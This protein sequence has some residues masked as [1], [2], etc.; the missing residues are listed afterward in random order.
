ME[1]CIPLVKDASLYK[2]I[3]KNIVNP[4]EVP[5]EAISNSI[6]AEAKNINIEL[7]RNN[8]GLFCIDFIDDGIGMGR[9]E[10]ERFFNLGD[11]CKD[12]R[13]IGEK[14]LG[15]KIFFRSKR[16]TVISQKENSERT[17]AVMDDPW[18]NLSNGKVPVYTIDNDAPIV[19]NDG[20]SVKIEGYLIDNPEKYFNFYTLKDYILWFT[21]GG[22]FKN[23]FATYSELN[24]YVKN[25]QVAPRIFINDKIQQVREEIGGTH[26]FYPPQENPKEDEHEKVYRKSVNYCRHFGPYHRSTNI[27]GEYVS[28]QMYGTVSGVNCRKS[29]CKLRHSERLK[30]RFGVYL[31][32]DFIPVTKKSSLITNP[33]YHHFH[34]VVNSQNF[35]LTADRN[36]I[37]NQDDPKVKWILS[38]AKKIIDEDI[39][40]I[41]ESVYFKM[42][43][44]EECQAQIQDKNLALKNR[45]INFSKL[46]GLNI[47]DIPIKKVPDNESQVALLLTSLLSNNKFKQHIKY[48]DSIAHYSQHS[49][50]DLICINNEGNPLLVEMEFLLSNIFKHDH[51]YETFDCIVC[52]K[53]DIEVNEKKKLI[54][55]TE[56]KLICERERWLL[57]FGADKIIPIIELSDVIREVSDS[58][59]FENIL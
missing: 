19:G 42:R 49:T 4:L 14:G 39:L 27:N 18:E 3:A 11:S 57:K 38:S 20:T 7:Y 46:Q 59:Y 12:T 9:N 8:E 28:F 51:P 40:P 36:N 5:R 1:K 22:S 43:K 50:T 58:K 52:W 54:D 41:A 24:R 25:M 23:L 6:D 53:I 44:E 15:T 10:M 26:H 16:I 17:I 34:L 21:A 45:L 33:N 32:K 31:A 35:E 2:E 48:I 47:D 55:G 13:N 30:N 56:L 29:I 37:S